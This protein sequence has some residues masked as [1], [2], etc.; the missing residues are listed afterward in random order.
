MNDFAFPTKRLLGAVVLLLGTGL[1]ARAQT[2]AL[3]GPTTTPA[4][5]AAATAA[6][7]GGGGLQY[8]CVN[9][10]LPS[11][12]SNE[13]TFNF[14]PGSLNE[15]VDR[16]TLQGDGVASVGFTNG[17]G[18]N[19][20]K[21]AP[22]GFGKARLT[23]SYYYDNGTAP[24]FCPSGSTTPLLCNGVAVRTPIRSYGTRTYEFFKNFTQAQAVYAIK[25][26]T[27]VPAQNPSVVYSVDNPVVS[28]AA[29]IAA[30]IQTDT[31]TWTAFYTNA[32][33]ISTSNAVPFTT[34]TD[35]TTITIQ[36]VPSPNTSVTSALTGSFNLT[37]RA[38]KCNGG[39]AVT[40]TFVAVASDLTANATLTNFPSCLPVGPVGTTGST[41]FTLANLPGV[42]YTLSSTNPAIVVT[43]NTI[44]ANATFGQTVTLAGFN[45]TN[46]SV[47]TIVGTATG[48][49]CFGTQTIVRPITRQ[50]VSAL[51][52][53]TPTCVLPG[54][55]TTLN[56][57]NAPVGA[58][59]TV[60]GTGWSIG[61]SANGSNATVTAG[62]AGT[63]AVVTVTSGTCGSITQTVRA[64]GPVP[65]CTYAIQDLTPVATHLYKAV[66]PTPN[67]N[68]CLPANNVYT[69]RLLDAAGAV[70]EGPIVRNQPTTT[71]QFIYGNGAA[72]PL[73]GTTGYT[74]ELRVENTGNCLNQLT[75]L[76]PNQ[77]RSA[78]PTGGGTAA[79]A[80]NRVAEQVSIF[81]NPG[82]EVV[83]I[84]LPEAAKGV[85]RVTIA[86]ALGRVQ[87]TLTT[88]TAWTPVSVAKLP[89]G[90]Y[91]VRVVLADGSTTTQNLLV[92]H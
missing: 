16:W 80:A 6:Q 42:A 40:T 12:L 61:S 35:G 20:F 49:T 25:G 53:I 55:A 88:T 46:A 18:G 14:A 26:P 89:A 31:Y 29:Q 8:A 27:C 72:W 79:P 58:T 51:N 13:Q 15:V 4:A 77:L 70:L 64:A 82:N 44:A 92:N 68:T 34:T 2:I 66:P 81:P 73:T 43:P 37:L 3:N 62:A 28:T 71:Y 84:G 87:Q 86:D 85:A 48:T 10:S 78:P 63:S 45:N 7:V 33:G 65:G 47:I 38:G 83:N 69:W 41:T 5:V 60:A 22:T 36:G 9:Y 59:W 57:T 39:T 17:Q 67:T 90:S 11:P 32:A 23:V 24:V 56:M 74:V 52:L 21:F 19:T 91:T 50:L 75:P 1:A 30:G 76:L 54:V